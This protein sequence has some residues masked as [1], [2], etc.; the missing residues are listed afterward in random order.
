[1]HVVD[2]IGNVFIVGALALAARGG[3]LAPDALEGEG[4]PVLALEGG[5]MQP[6]SRVRDADEAVEAMARYVEER[7]GGRRLRIGVGDGLAGDLADAL[8]GRLRA[9]PAV[10]ELVRYEVGPSV[11]AHTGPGTVGAVFF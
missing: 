6:V 9:G 8:E 1:M 3:R 2:R 5:K 11:G 4:L 10:D 7:S